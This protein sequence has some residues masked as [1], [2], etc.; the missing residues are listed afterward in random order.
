VHNGYFDRREDAEQ[1]RPARVTRDDAIVV[2]TLSIP[3]WVVFAR[4]H[5]WVVAFA[6]LF[7]VVG[8]AYHADPFRLKCVFPLS[9]KTEGFFAALCIGAGML[10][11][12][13]VTLGWEHLTVAFLVGGGASLVA[14]GKDYK[15]V[16]AD[17]A[18]GVRT[19]FVVLAGRGS[20]E[21]K[22][23]LLVTTLTAAC[24]AV[25]VI[26]IATQGMPLTSALLAALAAPPVAAPFLIR[27]RDVA[28]LVALAGVCCYLVVAAHGLRAIVAAT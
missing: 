2:A 10:T 9:Y 12:P 6:V 19:V 28:A 5:F 13:R 15:D 18:A 22:I 23:L 20:S 24:L 17:T 14:M 27:R 4:G 16:E 21:R 26:W 3:L 11:H 25:P 7:T 8:F 1:N